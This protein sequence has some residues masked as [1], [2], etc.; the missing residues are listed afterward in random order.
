MTSFNPKKVFSIGL[1]LGNGTSIAY[2]GDWDATSF[3]SC[4]TS[5]GSQAIEI[6]IEDSVGSARLLPD[7]FMHL[8]ANRKAASITRNGYTHHY[9]L[10]CVNSIQINATPSGIDR[11]K[12]T[13]L[14]RDFVNIT[15]SGLQEVPFGANN[16]LVLCMGMAPALYSDKTDRLYVTEKLN[17]ALNGYTFEDEINRTFNIQHVY[18]T[19]EGL[20]A[21][22]DHVLTIDNKGSIKKDADRAKHSYLIID[23]GRGTLDTMIVKSFVISSEAGVL[24]NLHTG[25]NTLFKLIT[26]NYNKQ[27]RQGISPADVEL[28]VY[29]G[30]ELMLK[31]IDDEVMADC[32]AHGKSKHLD[33]ISY[34]VADGYG[35]NH[36]SF[37][38][39]LVTGGIV[40]L[41]T[42]EELTSKLSLVNKKVHIKDSASNARGFYLTAKAAVYQATKK[43]RG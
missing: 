10:S 9:G 40:N 35:R 20:G 24:S 26:D 7:K 27:T 15:V 22:Y 21:Y 30:G 4:N 39:I 17:Q 23:G 19:A 41:F 18:Y 29:T 37:D 2:C 33:N 36:E 43:K 14:F 3:I 12:F 38:E 6:A 32:I 25:T 31:T 34:L 1:D 5:I 42:E 11:Y 28:Y 13:D 16:D 8:N